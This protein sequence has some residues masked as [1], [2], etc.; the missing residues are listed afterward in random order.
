MIP[1]VFVD[2][3]DNILE[4]V[5][6]LEEN[7]KRKDLTWIEEVNAKKQLD[8]LKKEI[9][10]VKSPGRYSNSSVTEELR[11]KL[12]N[13]NN[14]DGDGD[15]LENKGWS[16]AQTAELL[17]VSPALISED[18]QLANA[19]I[20]YPELAKVS[21]KTA[22][23]RAL[24]LKMITP[25]FAVVDSDYVKAR[26]VQLPGLPLIDPKIEETFGWILPE[27]VKI[28]FTRFCR[29]RVVEYFVVTHRFI[30]EKLIELGFL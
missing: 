15:V 14:F 20:A 8:E 4:R 5:A 11:S 7:L 28:A 22:A 27:H 29:E 17:G 13:P 30:E 2:L 25:S 12:L 10:G 24:R 1:C 6:E 9:H 26:V 21:S 23:K 3:E 19:L 18:I 16:Q